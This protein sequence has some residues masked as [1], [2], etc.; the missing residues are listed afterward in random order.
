MS[1]PSVILQLA[2]SR[3][4]LGCIVR[5]HCEIKQSVST[6][7]LATL[8]RLADLFFTCSNDRVTGEE[9]F[10]LAAASFRKLPGGAPPLL[11]LAL[12]LFQVIPAAE[13]GTLY[14]S[15]L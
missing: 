10:T 11:H 12:C 5:Q 15:S 14:H 4:L 8:L 7:A 9:T 2:H 13:P 3:K 1:S 6:H